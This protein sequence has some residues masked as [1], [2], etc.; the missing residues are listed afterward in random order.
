MITAGDAQLSDERFIPKFY[1]VACQLLSL[2]IFLLFCTCCK[3]NTAL[4]ILLFNLWKEDEEDTWKHSS[5]ETCGFFLC[6]NQ[7][8]LAALEANCNHH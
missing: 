8:I 2:I 6:W 1:P 4:P 7:S 3:I 5:V